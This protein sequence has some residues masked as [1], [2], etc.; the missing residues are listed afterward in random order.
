MAR[1]GGG[2]HMHLSLPLGAE[3]AGWLVA[4]F[5]SAE[6]RHRAQAQWGLKGLG[7]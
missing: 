1:L 6:V 5:A 7:C 4:G 3:M 2:V